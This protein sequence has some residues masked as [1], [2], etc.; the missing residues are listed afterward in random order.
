[1]PKMKSHS[2]TKKRMTMLKSGKIKRG[3]TN[4]RH[5]LVGKPSGTNA[6]L[7]QGAYVHETDIKPLQRLLPYGS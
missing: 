1:M 4:R 5:L 2:G 3:Q 7:R 6:R